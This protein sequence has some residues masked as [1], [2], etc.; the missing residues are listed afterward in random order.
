MFL[1]IS[2]QIDL[3][4]SL[5]AYVSRCEFAVISTF[6]HKGFSLY[7]WYTITKLKAAEIAKQYL[8]S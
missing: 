5:Y 6:S 4:Y 2:S 3:G 1:E 8:G 7:V